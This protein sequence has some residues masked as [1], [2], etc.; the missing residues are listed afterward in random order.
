M[1]TA[2]AGTLLQNLTLLFN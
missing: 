1:V 2:L